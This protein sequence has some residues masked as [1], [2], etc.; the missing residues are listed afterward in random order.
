MSKNLKQENGASG[1]MK[2]D[3]SAIVNTSTIV[4]HLGNGKRAL[5]SAI[6]FQRAPLVQV[7]P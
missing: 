2:R 7:T 5:V 6:C 3:Y 4:M 1:N